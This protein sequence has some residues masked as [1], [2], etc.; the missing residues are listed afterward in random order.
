MLKSSTC[1]LYLLMLFHTPLW[2]CGS[3]DPEPLRATLVTEVVEYPS[4]MVVTFR[5]AP[6]PSEDKT[7]HPV[8]Q[9]Y[10]IEGLK[11][12]FESGAPVD[13]MEQRFFWEEGGGV[14]VVRLGRVP[15]GTDFVTA[16]GM[17][18]AFDQ[19]GQLLG[20]AQAIP[21]KI[22]LRTPKPL[23]YSLSASLAPTGEEDSMWLDIDATLDRPLHVS[24][25]PGARMERFRLE[26]H[27]GEETPVLSRTFLPTAVG[28]KIRMKVPSAP[29]GTRLKMRGWW[30]LLRTNSTPCCG[31]HSVP[32]HVDVAV[33]DVTVQ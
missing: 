19:S 10:R 17:F 27:S 7:A 25:L 20:A 21:G 13:V 11:I 2:G 9:D 28:G 6:T 8:A 24:G 18:Q 15:V 5:L 30:V 14:L 22:D 32:P 31:E 3:S 4:C 12:R 26:S 29:V 33:K 23:A 1:W 16:E